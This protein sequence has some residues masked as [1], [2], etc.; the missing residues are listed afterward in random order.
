MTDEIFNGIRSVFNHDYDQ[1][2]LPQDIYDRMKRKGF[3]KKLSETKFGH[4][5]QAF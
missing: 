4:V 5:F 1:F 2:L 3:F